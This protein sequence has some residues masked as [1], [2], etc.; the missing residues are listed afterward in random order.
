MKQK[1]TFALRIL[2]GTAFLIF[3]LNG[4]F[5]FMPTPPMSAAAGELM[6]ALGKTGFFFPFVKSVEVVAGFFI[7]ANLFLPLG[8]VLIFPLMVGITLIHF[9]LNQAGLP[10]MFI[11]HGMHAFL[12]LSYWKNFKSVL[13][14]K[15]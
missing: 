6:M 12:V 14:L 1:I 2:F 3:G 7:L 9:F 11:L 13:A 15:A 5:N 4:F 10:I 8:L